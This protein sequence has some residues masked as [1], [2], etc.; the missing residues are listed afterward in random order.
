VKLTIQG[1]DLPTADAIIGLAQAKCVLTTVVSTATQIECDLNEAPAAGEWDVQIVTPKG[2]IPIDTTATAI[3]V[4]LVVDSI[5]PGANLN[6]LGGDI[7][8]L[9]GSGFSPDL[10]SNEVTFDD[11]TGCT[12]KKTTANELD[13]E[14]DGFDITQIKTTDYQVTVKSKQKD[15]QIEKVNTGM[16]VR[17]NSV[18]F[19]GVSVTPNSVSPVLKTDL[20]VSIM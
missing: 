11:N 17:L 14:V 16:T 7:L 6:Q 3:T 5:T 8:K 19:D 13:C 4:E 15:K 20:T 10:T 2:L 1:T 9:A 12:I 18:K